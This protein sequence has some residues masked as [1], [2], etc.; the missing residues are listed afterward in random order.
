[1]LKKLPANPPTERP[2][3]SESAACACGTF[4]RIRTLH[5]ISVNDRQEPSHSRYPVS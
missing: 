2:F 5:S 4:V 1:M 3:T